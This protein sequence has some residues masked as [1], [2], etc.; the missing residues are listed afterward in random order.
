MLTTRAIDWSPAHPIIVQSDMQRLAT[1]AE[2]R[3]IDRRA[4]T[5]WHIPGTTLMEN[6]GRAVVDAIERRLSGVIGKDFVILCGKGN[7]GGDGF[8][9]ARFL[10]ERG[11]RVSCLL[12]GSAAELK[13]D[14]NAHHDMLTATGTPVRTVAA[15]N[16]IAPLLAAHPIV[17]DAILGT[18]LSSAPRGLAADA[19]ELLRSSNCRVVSVD[20]PSGVDSDTG[21]TPGAAAAAEITVTMGLGKCGLYLHP[22]RALAGAVE[23]AD[24]GFP[25]ELLAGGHTFLLDEA[26]I[27]SIIPARAPDGHKGTFGTALVV[28]GSR[29]F[30]GAA[31]LAGAAAVRSGCGLVRLAVPRGICGIVESRVLEATKAPMPETAGEALGLAA[32]DGLLELAG[33][34][35]AV[36]IG[37]GIGTDP[38]TKAL[39]LEL[40]PRLTRPVLVDAD[41][42]NNLAGS[43][44]ALAHT[45]APVI[46]TPHPGEFSRLTRLTPQQVNADRI[47]TSREFATRH[48]ITLVLKG[49][50]TVIAAP[51]GQ[52]FVNPTGNSG[53]ASGG[54]GDVLSGLLVGLLA[55][56]MNPL[57]AAAAAVFLH[58]R[59]ADIAVEHFTEYCLT[60]GDVIDYLPAAFRSV[61][62]PAT[63]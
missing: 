1:A 24:I 58:G 41:G 3:A 22:G 33:N 13:G 27:R 40:L 9:V 60:A 43:L 8:A 21:A 31:C 51:D 12:L 62:T 32:L 29:G 34:A 38:E 4:M 16:E 48:R 55:Q 46:L 35:D 25:A 37:P 57:D 63:S 61:L 20:V 49:S 28:A 23:I 59:A 53:L 39:V 42:L 7:N 18:G 47:G 36:A 19:L 15:A 26:H 44:D 2:M 30:S 45:K 10:R 52:V 5:D 56:G 17:V 50:S 14:A 11:A 6:A 54:T